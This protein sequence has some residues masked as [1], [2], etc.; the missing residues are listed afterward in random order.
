[1]GKVTPKGERE[2]SPEERLLRA[3]FGEKAGD[4]RDASLKAPPGMQGIVIDTRLYSRKDS[5]SIAREKERE[6]LRELERDYQQRIEQVKETRNEKLKELLGGKV[7]V[8]LRDGETDEVVI[9]AR[10]KYTESR[11]AE[12]DF[13]RVHPERAVGDHAG[14]N[15]QVRK[16]IQ[17]SSQNIR[18]LENQLEREQEKIRRGDELAPA[19]FNW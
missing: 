19:S 18:E 16:V 7:C 11:L 6:T 10:W 17:A 4:V 15:K 8:E 9:Q 12:L 5:D 13:D 14:V 3:I 2:L 1:M